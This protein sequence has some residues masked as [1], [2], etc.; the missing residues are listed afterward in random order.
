MKTP[1]SICFPTSGILFGPQPNLAI[2]GY[3]VITGPGCFA[4]AR[5]DG[6]DHFIRDHGTHW[7]LWPCHYDG[8][9]T[10]KNPLGEYAAPG[11]PLIVPKPAEAAT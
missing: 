6:R 1:P 10:E 9:K 11:A 4:K 5:R 3:I 2:P 8:R 7:A